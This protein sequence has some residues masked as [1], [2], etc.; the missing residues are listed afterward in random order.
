M[1]ISRCTY[2]INNS[3]IEN[4][5]NL[6]FRYS[7]SL[8]T[9]EEKVYVY[10]FPVFKYKRKLMLECELTIEVNTNTIFVNVYNS[11]HSTYAPFYNNEYG[12]FEPLLEIVNKNILREFKKLGVVQKN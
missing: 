12:N 4:I 6:G 10:R 2:K 11:N 3:T 7:N 9:D 1:K 8:S 5:R